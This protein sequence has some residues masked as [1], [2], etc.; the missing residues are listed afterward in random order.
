MGTI[1]TVAVDRK[2]DQPLAAVIARLDAFW[3][4]VTVTVAADAVTV[5]SDDHDADA[6]TAIWTCALLNERLVAA[7]S[8]RRQR[9]LSDLVA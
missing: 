7:G 5:S 2:G 4:A 8:A 3:P 9:V 6:L 1:A